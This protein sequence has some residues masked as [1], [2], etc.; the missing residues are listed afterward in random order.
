MKE[1]PA[2]IVTVL[3][4]NH[5]HTQGEL[6]KSWRGW[7]GKMMATVLVNGEEHIGELVENSD[8]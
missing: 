5:I 4:S 6:V 3:A 7:S 2:K 1:A 8:K